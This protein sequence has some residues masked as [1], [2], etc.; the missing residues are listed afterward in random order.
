[1]VL[2]VGQEITVNFPTLPDK[3]EPIEL[4]GKVAWAMPE[5]IGVKFKAEDQNLEA[6]I[7]SL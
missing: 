3:H 5:G 1:M 6:M 2:S 4:Y 7:E